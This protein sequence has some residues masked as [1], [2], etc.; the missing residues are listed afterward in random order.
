MTQQGSFMDEKFRNKGIKTVAVL[1]IVAV[2]LGALGAHWLK[3]QISHGTISAEQV[4][5]FDTGV[6]YQMYHLLAMLLLL[7]LPI[8]LNSKYLRLAYRFF[9]WGIL[10]FSG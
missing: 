7:C 10:L 2:S 9:L 4:A 6:K 5:G 1:G 3:N 8:G